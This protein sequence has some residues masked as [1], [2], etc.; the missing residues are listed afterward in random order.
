MSEQQLSDDSK[1]II[2]F[3]INILLVLGVYMA[4]TDYT[5][6]STFSSTCISIIIVRLS[7][8]GRDND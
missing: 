5:D 6:L 1:T 2:R 4:I 3:T 7:M 8:R